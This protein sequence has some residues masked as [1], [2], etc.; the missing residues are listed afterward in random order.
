MRLKVN[1]EKW[2]NIL[3]KNILYK[4]TLEDLLKSVSGTQQILSAWVSL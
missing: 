3:G 1:V 4:Q 2:D